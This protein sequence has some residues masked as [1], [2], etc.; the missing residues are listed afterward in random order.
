M[1]LTVERPGATQDAPHATQDA[2]CVIQ[3]VEPGLL[4]VEVDPDAP[5]VAGHLSAVEMGKA[6]TI[7]TYLR[8]RGVLV[9][10]GQEE[11]LLVISHA[12]APALV[13]RVAA[14]AALLRAYLAC[15]QCGQRHSLCPPYGWCWPC[16]EEAQ[17][18]ERGPCAF[19][20]RVGEAGADYPS[21]EVP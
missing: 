12:I 19:L 9:T 2:P 18:G 7:L 1:T 14:N 20:S 10:A 21:L 17:Q 6:A 16:R 15:P 3:A 4:H 8:E 13:T 5:F 11:I